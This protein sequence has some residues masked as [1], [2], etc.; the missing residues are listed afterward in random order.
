MTNMTILPRKTTCKK[1][2]KLSPVIL[3]KNLTNFLE[4]KYNHKTT[5]LR[6][7]SYRKVHNPMAKSND[8]THQKRMDKN[9][10]IPDLVQV[11]SNVENSGLN[12]V[13]WR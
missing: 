9:C 13:L 10:H 4:K 8:K 2:K 1:L 5:E 3:N 6:G 12:L 7:K 11:F